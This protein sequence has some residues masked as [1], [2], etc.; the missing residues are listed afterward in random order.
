MLGAFDN[1][2]KPIVVTT[3]E[4]YVLFFN[5][6]FEKIFNDQ[7]EKIP[8]NILFLTENDTRS[9]ELLKNALIQA[10]T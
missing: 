4:G 2:D 6:S 9:T 7:P 3:P 1:C 10:Y 8:K 5:K